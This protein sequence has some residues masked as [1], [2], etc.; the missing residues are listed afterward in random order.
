MGEAAAT[1]MGA[2]VGAGV[3]A[4]G[5]GVAA[6]TATGDFAGAGVSVTGMAAATCIGGGV[7]DCFTMAGAFGTTVGAGVG[8]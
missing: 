7:T 4:V 5:T 3:L 1:T 2:F 6:A 8:F